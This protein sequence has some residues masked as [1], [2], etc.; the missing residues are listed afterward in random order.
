MG[1]VESVPYFC[2]GTETVADIVNNILARVK[3]PPHPL[4]E[5]ANTLPPE[6]QLT[7]L[8]GMANPHVASGCDNSWPIPGSH[9]HTVL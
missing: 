2:A 4:E 3:M 7:A 5:Q 9:K 8:I 1:W 6:E